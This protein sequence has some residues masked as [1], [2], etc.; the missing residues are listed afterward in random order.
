MHAE[1]FSPLT[2]LVEL[3]GYEQAML[4]LIDAPATCHQLLDV[5]RAWQWPRC[6]ATAAAIPMPF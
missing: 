6:N 4:A 1:V 5:F 2:H 3:L